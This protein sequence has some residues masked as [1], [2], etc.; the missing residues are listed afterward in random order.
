MDRFTALIAGGVVALV[1][2][3]LAVATF[4]RGRETPPDPSTPS[5]VALAYAV[6]E[7]HGDGVTAWNL[8]APSAQARADRD[9]FIS[10]V[11][12]SPRPGREYLTTEGERIEADGGASVFLVQTSTGSGGLFGSSS[13]SNRVS[14]RLIRAGGDWRITVPPDDYALSFGRP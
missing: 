10:R 3:G 1:V 9:R 13:A 5:G 8:L 12:S 7:Q 14:V 6:A 4:A 11:T 2:A